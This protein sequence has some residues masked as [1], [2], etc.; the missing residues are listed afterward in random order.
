MIIAIFSSM[1]A[2]RFIRNN[3]EYCCHSWS[4]DLSKPEYVTESQLLGWIV[5]F[6]LSLHV[7]QYTA[8]PTH[9][10]KPRMMIELIDKKINWTW[11]IFQQYPFF[12]SG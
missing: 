1:D 4:I 12:L 5:V 11:S 7:L 6:S 9:P 3:S 10:Q 8:I 2:W